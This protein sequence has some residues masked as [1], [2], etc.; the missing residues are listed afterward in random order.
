MSNTTNNANTPA[1]VH[2][3]DKTGAAHSGAAG[4]VPGGAAQTGTVHSNTA[5]VGAAHSNAAQAHNSAQAA[6]AQ[7]NASPTVKT[8]VGVIVYIDVDGTI[9]P[10]R[11]AMGNRL[12]GITN[13]IGV[14][15]SNVN[16]AHSVDKTRTNDTSS[17]Q[18]SSDQHCGNQHGNDQ[19]S[20][21]QSH[22]N[23][24]TD[25]TVEIWH[26]NGKTKMTHLFMER[27]DVGIRWYVM[28]KAKAGT[29]F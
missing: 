12:F 13:I 8:Y 17:D 25:Y 21:D 23:L 3:A 5:Q 27:T 24:V 15:N 14:D 6:S 11:I 2:S 4:T 22:D 28:R 1:R 9:K 10:E 26:G 19:R 7:P 20:G 18:C 29:T 16:D